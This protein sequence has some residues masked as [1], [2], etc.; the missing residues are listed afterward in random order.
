MI[1]I[2]YIWAIIFTCL[3]AYGVLSLSYPARKRTTRF[4]DREELSLHE[5]YDRFYKDS[6]ITENTFSQLWNEAAE[7]L[8]ISS[9]KLRP[10]D[11]L[12]KE[13]GP[14]KG[15]PLVDLNEDLLNVMV[16]RLRAHNPKAKLSELKNILSLHDYIT[17][18]GRQR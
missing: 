14:V 1:P 10:T 11:R 7:A 15:F 3:L 4:R 18:L 5:T 9:G 12:D 17:F 2:T 6:G 13:L 16:K 8:G